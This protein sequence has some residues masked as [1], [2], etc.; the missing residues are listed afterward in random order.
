MYQIDELMSFDRNEAAQ[1]LVKAVTAGELKIKHPRYEL[2]TTARQSRRHGK[3]NIIQFSDSK[4]QN[5]W[6]MIQVYDLADG[7]FCEDDIINPNQV[8]DLPKLFDLM[9]DGKIRFDEN[10]QNTRLH[11]LLFSQIRPYHYM[12]DQLVTYFRLKSISPVSQYSFTDES[13][14]YNELPDNDILKIANDDG[15]YLFP[16]TKGG[17][18]DGQYA[19]VMHDFLANNSHPHQFNSELSLW[20]GITAQKRSWLEQT[21]GYCNIVKQLRENYSSIT[22]VIDGWTRFTGGEAD[23]PKNLSRD[24]AVFDAI[25]GHLDGIEGIQLV[26]LIGKSYKEKISYSR[27]VDYFVANSGT[28]GMVPMMFTGTQGVIHSNGRLHTFK[29][30]YNDRIKI[31]PNEKILAQDLALDSG[32]YSTDW[33]VIYN[34]L[35]NLMGEG[36]LLPEKNRVMNKYYFEFQRFIFKKTIQLG[37]ALRKI[38]S[39][40]SN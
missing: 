4:G 15:C 28:G 16:C 1:F 14:F 20:F 2:E 19:E 8:G 17:D 27:G 40:L 39:K 11:G 38:K 21:E 9:K 31:V 30:S 26:N 34:L 37:I 3:S 10:N 33:T 24:Q 22:V 12:Y 13:C 36:Q 23:S 6:Y 25:A 29:R 7:Y 35:V 32:V 18:Y 5:P